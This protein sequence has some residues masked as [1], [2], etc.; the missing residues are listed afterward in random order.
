MAMNR[1]FARSLPV[2]ACVVAASL[3]ATA[4]VVRNPVVT[5]PPPVG[6]ELVELDRA[7]AEGLL[8]AEEYAVFRAR[9]LG[10][11]AQLDAQPIDSRTGE[12][13]HELERTQGGAR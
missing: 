10:G 1:V 13:R 8:S 11:L 7:R 5:R 9:L 12:A 6:K 4:C 2:V 3:A